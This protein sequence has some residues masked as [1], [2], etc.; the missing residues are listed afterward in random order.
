MTHSTAAVDGRGKGPATLAAGML[1]V[2]LGGFAYLVLR[3]APEAEPPPRGTVPIIVSSPAASALIAAPTP[4]PAAEAPKAPP[5]AAAIQPKDRAPSRPADMPYRFV[6][7]SAS[8]AETSI[9]LFGRGRVVT[10]HGPGPLDDEYVVDSVFDEYL[11]LRHV[12]T[13]VGKF[14]AFAQRQQ[15][16]EPPRDPEDSPRD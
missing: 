16:V 2:L 12:P 5:V 6:G 10:L 3:Q 15:V 11:V 1:L 14:L 4:V 9:M 8:G 7:K 13:G